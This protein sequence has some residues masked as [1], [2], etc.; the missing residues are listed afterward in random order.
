MAKFLTAQGGADTITWDKVSVTA[1]LSQNVI[2]ARGGV[3][4][5]GERNARELRTL[6]EIV[7]ALRA[8][9]GARVG[10][11]AM[12]RFN[13]IEVA[14]SQ[15]GWSQARHLEA[16]AGYEMTS[17][18]DRMMELAATAERRRLRMEQGAARARWQG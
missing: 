13:A 9:N 8:G 1:Y 3:R 15:G 7:D 17:A 10:D 4:A 12:G 14:I 16:V 11:I 6:A 2:G 5:V 18:G